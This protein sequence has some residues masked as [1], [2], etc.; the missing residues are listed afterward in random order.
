M[1]LYVGLQSLR[2]TQGKSLDLL[3]V[4]YDEKSHCGELKSGHM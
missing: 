4:A 2:Y 1:V 3:L